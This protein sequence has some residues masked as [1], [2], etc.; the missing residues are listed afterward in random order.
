MAPLLEGNIKIHLNFN[1]FYPSPQLLAPKMTESFIILNKRWNFYANQ[2]RHVVFEELVESWTKLIRNM[3][4]QR[5]ELKL[6]LCFWL[7]W[8]WFIIVFLAQ[9]RDVK[10]CGSKT[11]AI[12]VLRFNLFGQTP[13]R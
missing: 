10:G 5:A 9:V 4:I 3:N 6:K 11:A 2:Q 12:L 8:R 7:G 13:K 1:P